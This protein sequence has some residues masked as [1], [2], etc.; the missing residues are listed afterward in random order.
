[1]KKKR[2][3]RNTKHSPDNQNGKPNE[4][5][6]SSVPALEPIPSDAIKL[7][8]KWNLKPLSVL[9]ML[10]DSGGAISGSQ[11]LELFCRNST[12]P[13]SD[14]DIYLPA[15][16]EV[17]QDAIHVFKSSGVRW[18]N[19]LSDRIADFRQYSITIVPYWEIYK[20]VNMLKTQSYGMPQHYYRIPP[21]EHLELEMSEFREYLHESFRGELNEP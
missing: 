19:F 18:K 12:G 4:E 15:V 10:A 1:M 8:R 14:L 5:A 2:E 3:R 7:L 6:N 21:P 11:S 9:A 20:T 13:D 17:A 16:K